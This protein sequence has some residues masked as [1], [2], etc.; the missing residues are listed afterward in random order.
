[1]SYKGFLVCPHCSAAFEDSKD[2]ACITYRYLHPK[3]RYGMLDL[4]SGTVE[5][6]D[7]QDEYPSLV[8]I[9]FT[10]LNCGKVT[11]KLKTPEELLLVIKNGQVVE[12]GEKVPDL[13]VKK[14]LAKLV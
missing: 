2:E 13:A 6:Y 10:C 5:W 12:K 14:I 4:Q 11:D 8:E 7:E 1:M 9:T 3:V